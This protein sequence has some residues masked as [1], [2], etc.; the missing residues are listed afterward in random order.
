MDDDIYLVHWH[1]PVQP[2][3]RPR[4]TAS[5]HHYLPKDYRQW[6]IQAIAAF[7]QQKES[8]GINTITHPIRYYV[9]FSGKH[10]RRGD[11]ID[12]YPGALADALV[13][14]G[15]LTSDNAKAAPAAIYEFNWSKEPPTVVVAIAPYVPLAQAGEQIQEILGAV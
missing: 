13:D 9:F 1:G 3:A 8:M 2:N 7:V 15:V 6:K 5:G 11:L 12:N 4:G 14:A 10:N